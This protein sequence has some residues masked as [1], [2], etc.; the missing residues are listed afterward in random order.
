MQALHEEQV[1]P[2]SF[3]LPDPALSGSQSSALLLRDALLLKLRAGAG[4]FRCLGNV[5]LEPRPY[6]LVPLLMAPL[7][8][9]D[10]EVYAIA[11]GNLVVG[12]FGA[13]GKDGSR[14][15]VNVPSVGR[16]P[17]GATVERAIP[18]ALDSGEGTITL[19]LHRADFTTVSRMVAALNNAFGDLLLMFVM[20]T[21]FLVLPGFWL[22]SL[23]WVGIRA[24]HV[25]QGLS[26]GS[27]SAGQAGG[28]G[29]G[30]LTGGK[31]K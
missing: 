31:L 3:A 17:N 12:G 11:Q 5:A 10:G 8:G 23:T 21:M 15:S 4:P 6:Q 16:I 1:Q 20:G 18:N 7:R 29:A 22:A 25:I 30:A 28:K 13:Q 27:K 26:D 19:N 14:V 24:G 9:A 2:A